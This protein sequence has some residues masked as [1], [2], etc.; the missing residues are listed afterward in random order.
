MRAVIICI[1]IFVAIQFSMGQSTEVRYHDHYFYF[2][3]G[4]VISKSD[5]CFLD[6][7]T[8]EQAEACFAMQ[9]DY[10]A[11]HRVRNTMLISGA[12]SLLGYYISNQK[13]EGLDVIGDN[14]LGT[15]LLIGGGGVFVTSLLNLLPRDV[16]RRRSLKRFISSF[17]ETPQEDNSMELKIGTTSTGFGL[18]L[19]F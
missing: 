9:D 4:L 16:R 18:V 10:R 1:I 3:N 19:N 13:S 7:L 5:V 6:D 12:V 11:L 15:A 17:N 2:Q 8:P 14:T